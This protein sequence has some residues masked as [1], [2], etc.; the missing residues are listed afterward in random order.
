MKVGIIGS[1]HVGLVAGACLAEIGHSLLCTDSDEAKIRQLTAGTVPIYEPGLEDLVHRNAAA[2][3]L[4]FT[5]SL[6]ETVRATDILFICVGTPT[7]ETGEANLYYVDSVATE[8]GALLTSPKIIVDKSTVPVRTG[9]NVR[10]AVERSSGRSDFEVVSNPEFLREGSAVEDFLFPDRIVVGV[11]SERGAAAMREL[12]RPIVEQSFELAR[13]RVPRLP[14]VPL[15]VTTVSSAELIK[16][17]AN[18]FLALK[19]SYINALASVCELAGAD[20]E[21]VAEGLGLD[22]RIGKAFLKAGAGYGGYCLPKDIAAFH[23]ICRELG[24]DFRLLREVMEINRTAK[25]RIVQ[26]V[27]DALWVLRGKTIAVLGLAFKPNTDDMR[28]APSIDII[29]ALQEQGALIRA[30]DPHAMETAKAHLSD[31]TYCRSPYEA[32]EGAHAL[33]LLTEWE[34]FRDL[35]LERLRRAMRLPV[36]VDGRNALDPE[37][38]REAGFDYECVGRPRRPAA[39]RGESPHA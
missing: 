36:A 11:E 7:S 38:M 24:Y 17:A 25:Q 5:S 35:D 23:Q 18:S 33:V 26:K 21:E 3:R 34:E 12:Y 29:R 30:Y 27:A 14:S 9:A 39:R 4:G 28:A 32:A 22:R 6:A 31:V 8:I 2:G 13:R 19:I 1:G 20:V 10:R 16:H 37:R 15:I